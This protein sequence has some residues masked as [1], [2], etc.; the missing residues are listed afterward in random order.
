MTTIR[1]VDSHGLQTM[2]PKRVQIARQPKVEQEARAGRIDVLGA[3][4]VARKPRFVE[5]QDAPPTLGK[6][7]RHAAPRW[8]APDDDDLRIVGG[9]AVTLAGD[10]G[11]PPCG[12][13]D[14]W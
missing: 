7:G 14:G 10:G 11:R 8:S 5:Q 1:R 2:R 3:G 4:L 12:T 6:G 13:G 9:H